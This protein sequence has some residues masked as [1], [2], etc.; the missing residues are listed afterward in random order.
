[1]PEPLSMGLYHGCSGLDGRSW[2]ARRSYFGVFFFW[3]SSGKAGKFWCDFSW[4]HVLQESAILVSVAF[5]LLQNY[6]GH[7]ARFE[8]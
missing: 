6:F 7:R 8:V 4:L 2:K 1:M 5:H 3:Q